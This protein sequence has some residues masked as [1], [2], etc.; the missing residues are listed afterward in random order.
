MLLRMINSFNP[1]A[2]GKKISLRAEDISLLA[3]QM[4]DLLGADFGVA[5]SLTVLQGQLKDSRLKTVVARAAADVY[6]GG[7]LSDALEDVTALSPVHLSMIRAGESIGRMGEV[8]KELADMLEEEQ[9]LKQQILASLLYPAVVLLAG[10][11]SFLVLFVWVIPRMIPLFEDF[12]QELPLVTRMMLGI[13]HAFSV[14]W[15]ILAAAGI[16]GFMLGSRLLRQSQVRRRVESGCLRI[17]VLGTLVRTRMFVLLSRTVKTLLSAGVPAPE[18]LR[19]SLGTVENRLLKARGEEAFYAILSG[20]PM[21]TIFAPGYLDDALAFSL[22]ANAEYKG[23][24]A[25]GF[26]RVAGIYEGKFRRKLRMLSGLAEPV[27]ILG[28]GAGIGLVVFSILLP[29]MN[30]NVSV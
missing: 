4:A 25:E 29:L 11:F 16:A 30:L 7:N 2:S 23:C 14:S 20:E 26:G 27:L 15:W 28:L 5:E 1:P 13:S 24:P 3:R 18:A 19:A 21:A 22:V 8:F 9:A 6:Q 17:P 12:G 10:M